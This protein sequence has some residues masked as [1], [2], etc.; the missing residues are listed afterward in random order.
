[1]R[2]D[3]AQLLFPGRA[4][5]DSGCRLETKARSWGPAASMLCGLG[6]QMRQ[7]LPGP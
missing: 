3:G 1:M 2:T 4:A 6:E 5:L 7:G